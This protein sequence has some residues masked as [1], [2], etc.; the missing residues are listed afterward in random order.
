MGHPGASGKRIM[1][2]LDRE[3]LKTWI[4]EGSDFRL[5]DTLP[6]SAF[7]KGHLPGAI[8]IVSDD[9]LEQ[10]PER[11]PDRSVPIVVYCAS[12]TCRRAGRSAE[13]LESLWA[14][15]RRET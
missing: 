12:E 1:Q 4:D 8:N 6:A 14:E 15:V 7:E 3:T 5:V 2:Y 10:A 11:I 13:R 9:I